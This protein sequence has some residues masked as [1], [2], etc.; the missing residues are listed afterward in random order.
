MGTRGAVSGC[1]ESH[2]L[3]DSDH[4]PFLLSLPAQATLGLVKDL[5]NGRAILDQEGEV[6]MCRCSRSGLLV[7]RLD[8][9]DS[10]RVPDAVRPLH[11]SYQA[12]MEDDQNTWGPSCTKTPGGP[13]CTKTLGGPSCTKTPGGAR[14]RAAP[15]GPG[16]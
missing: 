16:S 2:Q 8:Q 7:I 1:F 14:H 3:K 6:E 5:A 13:S 4:V 10:D 11:I 12:H 9:F 15:D